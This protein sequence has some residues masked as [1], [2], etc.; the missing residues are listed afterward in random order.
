MA[1]C[2]R[3]TT[4]TIRLSAAECLLPLLGSMRTPLTDIVTG[5]GRAV[6]RRQSI[7]RTTPNLRV[8]WMAYS[9]SFFGGVSVVRRPMG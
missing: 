8:E 1:V 4:R 6:D 3:N 5:P 2:S 7:S 9:Q